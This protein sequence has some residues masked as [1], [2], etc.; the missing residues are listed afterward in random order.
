[1]AVSV[2]STVQIS[3]HAADNTVV[4]VSPIYVVGSNTK[5]VSFRMP[6]VEF[7]RYDAKANCINVTIG[8]HNATVLLAFSG[9]LV[10]HY[11]DQIK[12]LC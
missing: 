4:Y 9:V 10:M 1:M 5:R 7:D 8:S 2:A 12:T 6:Y 11:G 3:I